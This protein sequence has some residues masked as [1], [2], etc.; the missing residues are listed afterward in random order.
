VR[1]C[2]SPFLSRSGSLLP[3]T[4][5]IQTGA[6]PIHI[7]CDRNQVDL[8]SLLLSRG[9]AL[10]DKDHVSLQFYLSQEQNHTLA[11]GWIITPP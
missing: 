6:S 3:L 2:Q 1:Q 9:A 5:E 4:A 10:N 8:V 11:T 7:A